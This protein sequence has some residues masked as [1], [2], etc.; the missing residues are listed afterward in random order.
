MGPICLRGCITYRAP[1]GPRSTS[2]SSPHPRLYVLFHRF[3]R[4]TPVVSLSREVLEV[5]GYLAKSFHER[6]LSDVR[7]SFV[8]CRVDVK[9]IKISNKIMILVND[10]I[11]VIFS[12]CNTQRFCYD[13]KLSIFPCLN[14]FLRYP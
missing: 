3:A 8:R 11:I 7:C 2:R 12:Y 6:T 13:I 10:T 9:L 5:F 4:C 14:L 1:S